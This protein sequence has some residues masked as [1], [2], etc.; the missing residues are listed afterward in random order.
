[1]L[2]FIL[3]IAVIF[4]L[5]FGYVRYIELRSIFFPTKEIE[6]SP[7]DINLPFQDIYIDTED[8]L[9]INAW[10]I[11]YNNAKY[12]LLF[13]HG[14]GGNI[15]HRLDKIQLLRKAGVN[16]FIIDYRGY[17]ASQGRPTENGLYLDARGA[18]DYLLNLRNIKPGQIILY[19]ESMG[20]AVAINLASQVSIKA[21]ILEGGFSSARD[22]AKR[23]Y[24][25]LPA[26]LFS[27]R[28]DSLSKIKE[29][30]APKLFLHS[31][32]DEIVPF[33]LAQRLFKTASE[34]KQLVQLLG[35]HNN[36]FL[37][38]ENKYVSSI[39]SFIGGI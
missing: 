32:D 25:Y 13:F 21:L 4:G 14:N 34:P 9:K 28:F 37:D 36:A 23:Y 27:I 18:Y 33:K 5:I 15:S 22:M 12:T 20:T 10:F 7:T 16:I 39:I 17:G 11:P 1:M 19:G 8:S 29:I 24:P 35:G 26:F 38:S 31:Q 6:F 30:N 2:K 3:Y